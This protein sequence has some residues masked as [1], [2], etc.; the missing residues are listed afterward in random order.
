MQSLHI[1]LLCFTHYCFYSFII[2]CSKNVKGQLLSSAFIGGV[3]CSLDSNIF[4]Q[5]LYKDKR[6]LKMYPTSS[7]LS[8]M[9]MLCLAN[10]FIFEPLLINV[11]L[12]LQYW[13]CVNGDNHKLTCDSSLIRSGQTRQQV[14]TLHQTLGLCMKAASVI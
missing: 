3:F 8:D 11:G 4:I 6:I 13:V 1:H 10:T 9:L 14:H 12:Q 2:V 7:A 5:R